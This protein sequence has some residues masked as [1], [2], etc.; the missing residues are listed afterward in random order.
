MQRIVEVQEGA[1]EEVV[2]EGRRVVQENTGEMSLPWSRPR[3][4][5]TGLG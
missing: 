2:F 1:L 4:L 3:N 5:A